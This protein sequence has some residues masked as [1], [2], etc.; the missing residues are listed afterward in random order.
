MFRQ[1]DPNGNGYLSLAEIDKGVRDVLRCD[2]LFNCKPAIMRAYQSA[3]DLCRSRCKYGDDYVQ[4]MEFKYLLRF[5]R[6]YFDYYQM[7]D[8]IDKNDDRRITI[9]E[10]RMAQDKMEAY[11]IKIKDVDAEFNKIDTNGGGMILFDEFDSY[12]I[13]KNLE[14]NREDDD[15]EE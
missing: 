14:I 9:N 1:F 3:K 6:Q 4:W 7:F 5:L 10:F 13:K 8:Q 11:G 2:A 12:A 15:E